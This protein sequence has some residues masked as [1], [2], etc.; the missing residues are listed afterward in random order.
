MA[1]SDQPRTGVG[2]NR[3]ERIEKWLSD[4]SAEL[5]GRRAAKSIRRERRKGLVESPREQRRVVATGLADLQERLWRIE[6]ILWASHGMSPPSH[7]LGPESEEKRFKQVVN[8]C[9][10]TAKV[11]RETARVSG[12]E[13]E[14]IWNRLRVMDEKL[15]SVLAR[16]R[17]PR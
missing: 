16:A 1:P 2:E 14:L 13:S 7:S 6:G 9:M 12:K 15:D 11:N 17:L 10:E 8:L 5:E 4:H 3:R